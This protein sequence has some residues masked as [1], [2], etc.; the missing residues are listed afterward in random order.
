MSNNAEDVDILDDDAEIVLEGMDKLISQYFEQPDDDSFRKCKICAKFPSG[1]RGS[2]GMIVSFLCGTI[3]S[4]TVNI[5][6]LESQSSV[7]VQFHTSHQ[8]YS[9]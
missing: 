9:Q 1:L 5:F 7:N 2:A 3:S 8:A 6:I 4:T